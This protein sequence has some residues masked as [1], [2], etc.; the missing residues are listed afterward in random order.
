[1]QP[2]REDTHYLRALVGALQHQAN[3]LVN[4]VAYWTSCNRGGFL[5]LLLLLLSGSS[6]QPLLHASVGGSKIGEKGQ[7]SVKSLLANTEGG[8]G[9]DEHAPTKTMSSPQCSQGRAW[10]SQS[11]LCA[12]RKTYSPFTIENLERPSQSMGSES[13]ASKLLS[14]CFFFFLHL[15]I[16]KLKSGCLMSHNWLRTPDCNLLNGKIRNL[17]VKYVAQFQG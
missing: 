8:G 4:I 13:P 6:C 17:K 2:T 11:S 15:V 5:L 9:K 7:N 16:V 1:M 10:C 14:Q 12:Q 3:V